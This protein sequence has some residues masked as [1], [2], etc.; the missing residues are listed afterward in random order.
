MNKNIYLT[1][2]VPA[3][4]EENNL[5]PTIVALV[6]HIEPLNL[7][8]EILIIDDGSTDN[9]G[10]VAKSLAKKYTV[11][12]IIKHQKNL[13][14]GSGIFTGIKEAKGEFIIFIPADLAI[15]LRQFNKYLEMSKKC[16]IVVGMRSDRGDYTLF[17]KI[18]SYVNI[19]VIK[20]LFN[21]KEHQFNY[22]HL[23]RRKI[24]NDVYPESTGVFITA[25]IM[26]RARDLGYKLREIKIK[27]IP[28]KYGKGSCGNPKVILNTFRDMMKF[29]IKRLFF[30][31]Y[32]REKNS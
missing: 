14:P 23:Y 15:D 5:E 3:F 10:E 19:S 27:Y 8:F 21:M 13:G 9:T 4:N 28:R 24:F 32:K 30:N 26:I 25:E 1:V 6:S 18:V 12:R 20:M 11:I 2:I 22:I 17:R 16:D 29:W 7:S 31:V